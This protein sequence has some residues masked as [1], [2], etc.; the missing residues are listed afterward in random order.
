[1]LFPILILLFFAG[2]SEDFKK[3]ADFT[4]YYTNYDGD[5]K[6][7]GEFADIVIRFP[8]QKFTVICL[9]NRRRI[10][11]SNYCKKIADIFLF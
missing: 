3:E 5:D 11:P 8:D 2:C 1:M 4:A 10:N 9:T 7:S 6:I